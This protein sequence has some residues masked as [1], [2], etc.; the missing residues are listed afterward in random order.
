MKVFL[1]GAGGYLGGNLLSALLRS[2]A[3]TEVVC[4]IRSYEKRG[5]L[6]GVFPESAKVRYV[7][8]DLNAPA[9]YSS[10]LEGIDVVIHAA[11]M[12]GVELCESEPDKAEYVNV[13]GT[14]RL[15]EAALHAEVRKILYCSTQAVYGREDVFPYREDSLP[16]PETVYGQT[17]YRGELLVQEAG[18]EGMQFL[19]LRF[20]KLYGYGISMRWEELPHR[21][22]WFAV[23]G[24]PLPV[25][26]GGEDVVDLLHIRDAIAAITFF[27]NPE[28]DCFWN[29]VYNVGGGR[30]VS[31]LS[32]AELC[33]RVCRNLGFQIPKI[34]VFPPL[35]G[36]RP[37]ALGLDITKVGKSGWTP[38][39]SLEEGLRELLV[40][41][42][43]KSTRLSG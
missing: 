8:G 27:L 36:R 5:F 1:T 21:F 20:S 11:A 18:R 16:H 25:Y 39:V 4:L 37:R 23:S 28:K 19:V 29:D 30:P 3:I 6:A 33:Q 40:Y 43:Q 34:Q 41:A 38:L 14:E 32:L 22:A 42:G 7:V 13:R 17:K 31:V 24:I 15:V 2:Q 35:S 9:T 12:R 10:S 26:H